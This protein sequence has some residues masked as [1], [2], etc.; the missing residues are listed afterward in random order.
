VA[1]GAGFDWSGGNAEKLWREHRLTPEEAEEAFG[2]PDRVRHPDYPGPGGETR[3]AVA[4]RTEDGLL[5][6]VVYTRRQGRLRVVTAYPGNAADER[7][8]ERNRRR[9]GRR[10]P[11]R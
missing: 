7:A 1:G 9:W 11:R 6:V 2:D 4:G 3:R 8:Y 10:G 5:L